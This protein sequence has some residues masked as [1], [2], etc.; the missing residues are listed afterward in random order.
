MF[1]PSCLTYNVN[2]GLTN[3]FNLQNCPGLQW[4]YAAAAVAVVYAFGVRLR[5]FSLRVT[6]LSPVCMAYRIQIT[7]TAMYLHN[8]ILTLFSLSVSQLG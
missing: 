7:L 2:Q 3:I 1:S 5:C 6:V 8:F 4:S